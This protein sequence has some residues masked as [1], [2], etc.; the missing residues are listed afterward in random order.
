MLTTCKART[1]VGQQSAVLRR[2][3][4]RANHARHTSSNWSGRRCFAA[5]S[6]IQLRPS[7]QPHQ[8]TPEKGGMWFHGSPFNTTGHRTLQESFLPLQVTSKC[9][10]TCRSP[11]PRYLYASVQFSEAGMRPLRQQQ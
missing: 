9:H 5:P 10:D 11:K 1:Y 2:P 4:K 6:Y 7:H 3:K 8:R